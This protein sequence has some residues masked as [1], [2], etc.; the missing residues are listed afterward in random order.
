MIKCLHTHICIHMTIVSAP[1]VLVYT[2][3][4]QWL[5]HMSLI[6]RWDWIHL[7]QTPNGKHINTTILLLQP[8][9][10]SILHSKASKHPL[11]SVV[12][13]VGR[14]KFTSLLRYIDQRTAGPGISMMAPQL[15]TIVS[16]KCNI[17][18]AT[19][20]LVYMHHCLVPVINL[21]M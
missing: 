12:V 6:I 20:V 15:P 11:I 1:A 21:E 10:S 4:H 13:V 5:W 7:Q 9:P 16:D 17:S 14:K 18:C 8:W 3:H 2:C 19:P